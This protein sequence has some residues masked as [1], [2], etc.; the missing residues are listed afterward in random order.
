MD[1]KNTYFFDIDGTIV[2]YRDFEDFDTIPVEP[3]PD[4]VE[5]INQEYAKG[6]FIVLT[7][8]RPITM[9]QFTMAEM[10]SIGLKYNYLLLGIGRGPRFL[11]NDKSRSGERKA[12]S[13]NLERD[14]GL[15]KS[16]TSEITKVPKV[17]KFV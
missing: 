14:G 3:I 16:K 8:A 12:F 11:I 5:F 6:H 17:T 9:K 15:N 1:K 13:L 4:V 2:K 7:T 10:R